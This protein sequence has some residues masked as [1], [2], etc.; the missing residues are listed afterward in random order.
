V[1]APAALTAIGAVAASAGLAFGHGGGS[2]RAAVEPC[3]SGD[4]AVAI[5]NF[6]YTPSRVTVA[7][8]ATVCWTN[9]DFVAHTV[10]SNS[11]GGFDSDTIGTDQS[12]RLQFS[13]GGTYD[14][15]CT[16]HPFMT[17]Q[18][19]VSTNPQ[20]PPPPQP[21]S[22]PPAPPSPPPP[23]AR[24]M[25]LTVSRL[26]V[27]VE[28]KAGSRWL[29]ARARLSRAT[30]ARRALLRGRRTL[31]SAGRRLR[32]GT[33]VVRL[34]LPRRLAHGRYVCILRVGSIR[35]TASLHL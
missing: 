7:P 34:R 5:E 6:L 10:T 18:V 26:G 4:V 12:F 19:V 1:K 32:A 22:P 31:A 35:R 33:N 15:I 28:R 2:A 24:G 16:L 30:S 8:G 14:Y 21:P 3:Q 9:N 25:A 13:S 27:R 11:A 29:V 23:P 17:G 20:P